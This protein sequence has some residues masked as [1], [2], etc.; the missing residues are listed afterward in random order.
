MFE[1][2]TIILSLAAFFSYVN[3]KWLELPTTIGLMIQALVFAVLIIGSSTVT[4]F[5]YDFFC[6]VVIDID[7]KTILLDVMLSLLLFAGA[8]HINL[9]ALS[10][11]KVPILLFA[12]LGVVIST[13]LV[14][15]LL[16]LVAKLVGGNLPFLHCLLFG[17]LIS[18]TDPIAATSILR[19]AG[20]SETLDLKIEGESLFNDGIGV[21]VFTSIL[22]LAGMGEGMSE[23]GFSEIVYLFLEEAVGGLIFG[24]LLGIL[25]FR[26]LK[27][28]E[29]DPKTCMILTLAFVLGGYTTATLIHVSGPL[30]MVVTGLIIGNKIALPTFAKGSRELLHTVWEMM[31]DILNAV[32]FVMIGL[33]IH[34][35]N[36][37]TGMLL[38][39]L[40]AIV[41]VLLGRFVSVGLTYSLLK[42]KEHHPVNTI[43]FLSWGGLRGGISVALALSLP[44]ML[45]RDTI[46]FI[47]YIVVIFSIIVQGLTVGKVLKRLN[48]T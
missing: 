12:T 4:P 16:F 46:L 35:L 17:A 33:L 31:D 9:S 1:S 41:I 13:F 23:F 39:G 43:L 6:Q 42:H 34:A 5:I 38:L 26:L 20:I 10:R 14:G 7:F 25:G 32:L 36:Y 37:N 27:T 40:I 2:F 8:M 47:T 45:S 29:D 48:M 19:K 44:D 28:I 18:P 11:E 24:T 30:A 15:G 22:M 3:H 21:V